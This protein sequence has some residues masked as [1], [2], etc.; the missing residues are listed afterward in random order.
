MDVAENLRR[1]ERRI[2]W[3]CADAGRDPAGVR[4]LPVS[5]TQPVE[6][7]LTVAAHGYR[8]FGENRVQ[9]LRAKSTAVRELGHP[10]IGFSVI[11][12]LQTNKAGVVADLAHEFQALDSVHLA[13]ELDRRRARTARRLDVFVQVNSSGEASKS[14]VA[15]DDALALARE[16]RHCEWLRVRGLM[17]VAVNSVDP[18]PVLACFDRMLEVQRRLRDAAIEGLGWDEL[19]MGMTN[20]LELAIARGATCVRVGRAIFGEREGNQQ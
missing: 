11:G 15:P 19:S 6:A 3:A 7:I 16:L 18:E 5:K 14:G 4:L 2:A 10:E 1:V 12:H 8:L 9:E 13:R 17:T 20:D